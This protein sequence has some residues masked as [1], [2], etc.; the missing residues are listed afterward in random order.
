MGDRVL[1]HFIVAYR[2]GDQT[3]NLVTISEM[4]G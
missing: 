4:A 3:A 1:S 2:D